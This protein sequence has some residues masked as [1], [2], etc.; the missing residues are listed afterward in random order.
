MLKTY[1]RLAVCAAL[2]LALGLV[3]CDSADPVADEAGAQTAT[4][5]AQSAR[6][7]DDQFIV[8]FNDRVSDVPGLARSLAARQGGEAFFT[9]EHAIKGFAFRGSAQAAA[10]LERN[11]NVAY[12]E[13]DQ[14]MQA[15]DTQSNATWGLDRSD[16]RLLPLNGS[17]T[18]N[19]TAS[20]VHAYVIDTGI[21]SSHNDFGGR[22]QSACYDAFGD[23][24]EDGNGHG[25]HVAGTVGGSTWGVAKGVK[26]YAVRVLDDGGS[27]TNTGVIAGVDWV[28]QRKQANPTHDMVANMS[29]GGGASTA[30]DNAVRNS[31]AA[32]VT[33]AV[34]AGNGDWRG[35]QADACNYSPARVREALTVGA[36]TSSDAKT[37]WSNYGECVDLFAPGASITS[38]WYNSN[39]AT[40]TI[41]GTSMASPHVAGVAALYLAANPGASASQ[42]FQAI[43]DN[44]T[45]GI[46]TSSSTANNHL[47]YSIFDGGSTDPDPD[48]EPDP[49]NQAPTASFTYACTDLACSF[50]GSDSSDSDGSIS[51]YS[52]TFGDNTSGSGE[53]TSHTYGSGGDYTVMLTVTDDDGA[54]H[55]TSQTVS[56]S[57]SSGGG[58]TLSASGYKVRGRWTADLSWSGASSSS[59][60]VYRDGE[61][62]ATPANDGDYTDETNNRGGGS[63][64]YKVCEAGTQT[65]SNEATATF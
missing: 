6:A 31:I 21:R 11:P 20:N 30:L 9:Y 33:Y 55:S 38:A 61:K 58:I 13:R 14:V 26:L 17:Y 8:V 19:T 56:V 1:S 34:A 42:V 35:R 62:I 52:W 12:V 7:V 41:S 15:V 23:N 10:A 60:D 59:V 2:A 32:G 47:L 28:T 25:T 57:A 63:L 4:A 22:V 5:D 36:T 24:C 45:K 16:Q 3:G 49:E 29:L 44:T 27:G 65:C 40:N 43:Y 18:F 37:S 50:D 64:T 48:P 46:V 51:S 53:T 39:T 54:T